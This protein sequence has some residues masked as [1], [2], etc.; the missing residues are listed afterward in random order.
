MDNTQNHIDAF[1]IKKALHS[2]IQCGF[3]LDSFSKISNISSETLKRIAASSSFDHTSIPEKDYIYLHIFL[4]QLFDVSP[5]DDCYLYELIS[6]L[7]SFFMISCRAIAN[8]IGTSEER[9]LDIISAKDTNALKNYAP[10]ICHLY[11]TFSRN[12]SF[13]VPD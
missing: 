8:Y 9:L 11:A 3:S 12:R 6:S 1:D 4:S 13:S 10:E 5:R 2:F 7:N